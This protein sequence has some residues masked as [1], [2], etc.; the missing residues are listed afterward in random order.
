[1]PLFVGDPVR[2]KDV[3]DALLKRYDIYIQPINY[4]TVPRGGER[5]RLTPT[6]QHSDTEMDHLC[7]SLA[8]VW[9]TEGTSIVPRRAR[10]T[11]DMSLRR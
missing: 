5:L 10:V 11:A 1:V 9:G 6:P 8:R 3:S 7:T 2:C 4:P